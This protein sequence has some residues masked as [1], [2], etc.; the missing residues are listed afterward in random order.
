MGDL[1]SAVNFV[2]SSLGEY[3]RIANEV[4]RETSEWARL[5]LAK[6]CYRR[7]DFEL[8]RGILEPFMGKFSSE[9]RKLQAL[10]ILRK[11]DIE[12]GESIYSNF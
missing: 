9:N 8:V 11:M 4:E 7:R 10:Y 1:R 3:E 2:L 5:K 6:M 12:R